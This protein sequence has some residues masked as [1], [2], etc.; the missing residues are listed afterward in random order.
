MYDALI[1]GR[2]PAGLS[3]ALTLGRARKRVV[4]CDAGARRNAAADHI[5]NFV[6]QDGAPVDTLS[7]CG[8]SASRPVFRPK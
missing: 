4:L 1:V 3:A 6:T 2:G 5:Y 7:T 8:H